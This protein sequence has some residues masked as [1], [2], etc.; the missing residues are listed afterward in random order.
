METK[1]G[2]LLRSSAPHPGNPAILSVGFPQRRDLRPDRGADVQN[3][4]IRE[5][6]RGLFLRGV[7]IVG[8]VRRLPVFGAHAP[9]R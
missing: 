5:A 6:A 9:W 8:V 3:G 2:S 7:A 4:W 1:Y